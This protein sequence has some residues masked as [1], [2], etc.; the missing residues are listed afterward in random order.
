M[1]KHANVQQPCSMNANGADAHERANSNL[2]ATVWR[3]AMLIGGTRW[4][5]D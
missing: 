2:P 4:G 3:T 5:R 1:V